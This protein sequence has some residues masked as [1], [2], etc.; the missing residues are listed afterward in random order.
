MD[1]AQHRT[2]NVPGPG[3]GRWATQG[4]RVARRW[5]EAL[6][7]L[8][9][10]PS[11]VAAGEPPFAAE[12]Y[13]TFDSTGPDIAMET[14]SDRVVWSAEFTL[15]AWVYLTAPS[16]SGLIAGRATA[17]G[18]APYFHVGFRPGPAVCGRRA[19]W[20]GDEYRNRDAGSRHP[21]LDR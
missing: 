16:S 17:D 18:A 6:V 13:L 19:G 15:E 2:G 11:L 20:F 8:A 9:L 14:G 21:V 1:A 5:S 7:A 4:S 10:L 12:H 3:R